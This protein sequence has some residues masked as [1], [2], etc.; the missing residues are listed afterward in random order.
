MS[1]STQLLFTYPYIIVL[2]CIRKCYLHMSRCQWLMGHHSPSI[3]V[4][5][6]SLQI[7]ER[8]GKKDWYFHI[9]K[10]AW[11]FAVKWA[12]TSATAWA[13]EGLRIIFV[14]FSFVEILGVG[15]EMKQVESCGTIAIAEINWCKENLFLEGCYQICETQTMLSHTK[16]P[17]FSQASLKFQLQYVT[18][19]TACCWCQKCWQH[20]LHIYLKRSYFWSGN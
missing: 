11:A 18:G 14:W 1:W 20:P 12:N 3:T 2:E 5:E 15:V 17:T 7:W 16:Q 4:D 19:R 13:I 9:I 10:I 6:H 8:R